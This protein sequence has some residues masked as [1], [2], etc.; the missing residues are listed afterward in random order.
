DVPGN[1][2]VVVACDTAVALLAGIVIFPALFAFDIAPDFG[3]TLLIAD[4][5]EQH[6]VMAAL[7]Y[8]KIGMPWHVERAEKLVAEASG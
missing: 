1:A 5:P 4:L 7:I 6:V 8:R 3:Q 2:T